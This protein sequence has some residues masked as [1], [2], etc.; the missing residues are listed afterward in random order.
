MSFNLNE[1]KGKKVHM[2]GI[3]GSMMSGIA[4]ILI[5][6]D[7]R[8]SGSDFQETKGLQNARKMG[9]SV[10]GGHHR[11]NIFDQDLVVYTAAIK[12]DNPELVRAREL[13]IPVMTRSEFLGHLLKNFR[14]SVGIA[15]THGK[16]ST[17]SIMT[18]IAME[19]GMDPT[20]LVGAHMPLIDSN[21]RV[22]TSE[23]MIIESC[24][25]SRSFL[26]FPPKIAVLLNIEEDHVDIYKDIEEVKEAFRQYVNDVPDDGFVAANADDENIMEVVQGIKPHVI[27]YGINNGEVRARNI[28]LSDEGKATFDLYEGDRFMFNVTLP[29]PGIHNVYNSLGAVTAALILGAPEDGIKRG[30]EAYKGVDRR[31]QELG[32]VN[33]VRFIDDYGHH[34]TEVGVT[35][36]TVIHYKYNKLIVVE[37]PHTYSRLN[38]F[39]DDF[40]PLFDKADL[41]ILLPVY[42]AREIDTG[43]TS[44][45]KLADAIRARNTVDTVSLDSYE[46]AAELILRKAE[47]GDIVLLIGAG[48]G[49]KVFDLI[50]EDARIKEQ[51]KGN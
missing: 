25:Y 45:D 42:A 19:S 12:Q 36:D 21:Y 14:D 46:A 33:G 3:G 38:Y 8:V 32:T 11:D 6:N 22:G 7:V 24:E 50:K 39:F 35:M 20:V 18:A 37:Q 28:T 4:G 44:S 43:L 16:T 51:N 13:G 40:V 2:I 26:D 15:G 9:A 10:K 47:E 27:T 31:L 41:L 48:E 23:V 34:P 17:T 29:I 1:F 5:N 49:Y 30:L